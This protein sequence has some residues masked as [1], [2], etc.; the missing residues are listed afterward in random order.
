VASGRLIV[1]VIDHHPLHA[2]LADTATVLVDRYHGV[3]HK[4][5]VGR[6]HISVAEQVEAA[7]SDKLPMT[8]IDDPP[9]LVAGGPL[10]LGGTPTTTDSNPG[11]IGAVIGGLAP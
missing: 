3:A 11:G 1:A 6:H 4:A 7:P 9:Q 5:R 8:T 10:R 2:G